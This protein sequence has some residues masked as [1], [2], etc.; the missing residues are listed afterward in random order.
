[1]YHFGGGSRVQYHGPF[2]AIDDVVVFCGSSLLPAFPPAQLEEMVRPLA[3]GGV[4]VD[5]NTML[6]KLLQCRHPLAQ[7]AFAVVAGASAA[8]LVLCLNQIF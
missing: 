1:M 6:I 8:I 2:L 4:K 3:L 5:R 7:G